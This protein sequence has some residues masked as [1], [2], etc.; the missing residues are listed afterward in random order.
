MIA[1]APATTVADPILAAAQYVN[2]D[3]VNVNA[4]FNLSAIIV[5]AISKIKLGN[6]Q[7]STFTWNAA[8]SLYT[9]IQYQ[10]NGSLVGTSSS[11][12]IVDTTAGT[13]TATY[14]TISE[15]G[16]YVVKMQ[17]TS[18]NNEYSLPFTSNAIL[19]K[20]STSKSRKI[21]EMTLK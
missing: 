19:V 17:I 1:N 13:I 9:S 18:S 5:D 21:I 20:A 10:S 15:P 11:A 14:L 4:T 16:M 3:V 7:W 8:V 2:I 6:I 12:V